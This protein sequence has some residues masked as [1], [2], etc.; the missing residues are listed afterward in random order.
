MAERRLNASL[1]IGSL[2]GLGFLP[3]APGTYGAAFAA[4]VHLLI[5]WT[6]GSLA[7]IP[8]T[9]VATAVGVALGSRV[10]R[11]LGRRDPREFI[12]DEA[13]GYWLAVIGFDAQPWYIVIP[14]AFVLFRL[15]DIL[16]PPPVR[17]F[18]RLPG[19]WGIMGDDLV[20]GALTNVV[21]QIVF[22]LAR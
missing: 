18:E 2:G 5:L 22:L 16:K 11:T 8:L 1:L 19:G 13:A 4:G 12:L 21:L 17:W 10:E 9:V 20:A 14:A 15:G 7:L 6:G 3:G